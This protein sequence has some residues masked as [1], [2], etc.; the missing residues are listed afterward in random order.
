MF[1]HFSQP[2]KKETLSSQAYQL[3]R[4]EIINCRLKPGQFI[5]E[6]EFISRYEMSKTPI[7][8]ALKQLAQERLVQSIPGSGYLVTTVTVKDV[9]ELF[10]MRM[11]LEEAV[12]VRASKHIT[13]RQLEE[14]SALAGENFEIH[15]SDDLARWYEMNLAFHTHIARLSKNERLTQVL[16]N[17]LEE[18]SRF[19]IMDQGSDA[20]TGE[21][22]AHHQKIIDALRQ[23]DGKLAARITLE[24]IE[25]SLPRIQMLVQVNRY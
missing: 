15:C 4:R 8:E 24:D 16:H 17:N 13:D 22:V 19:L 6:S 9:V 18:V 25:T 12:A 23:R 10:E 5:N 7:R 11:I 20:H 14:L 1:E 3:I 2:S 21:W